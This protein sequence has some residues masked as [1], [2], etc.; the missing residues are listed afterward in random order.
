MPPKIWP[1]RYAYTRFSLSG[2][3]KI[4]KPGELLF[5]VGEQ[6]NGMYVLRKGQVLVYLDKGGT[7]IPLTTVGAGGMLGEMSLFDKKPRS[8]SAR[9]IDDVE[10]TQISNEDFTK[11]LQQIPKWF[12]TLMAT[13]S[14]RLRDTNERLQNLEGKYKGNFN[15]MEELTKILH[16]LH[17]LWYKSG[18]KELKNWILEREAAEN[19]VAAVLNMERTKV[20]SVVEACIMG[21]LIQAGKNSYKK[22]I[23]TILNRGD[24]ERFI[25][26]VS[27]LR[28]RNDTIKFL[29]Q[30]FV[31][32]VETLAK[33]AK[34]TAYDTFAI[35]LKS[36]QE[37]A[38]MRGFRTE[39]WG[40]IAPMFLDVDD[41]VVLTKNAK[42]LNLKVVK[43]QIDTL[44]QHAKIL[45]V[46]TRNEEKKN[47][48]A[49]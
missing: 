20:T 46:I 41:S 21:G 10:L 32:I 31:D 13:L 11:I 43:K 33:A 35:E 40:E 34:A 7:E 44:V 12:V 38:K 39:N 24:L 30:E 29:P 2:K 37:E 18:V 49:A 36:L 27:R 45:R 28:K 6:S 1:E 22:D 8:A 17:L 3:N 23:L 15:P 26:F 48:K 14:A 9:A 25:M 47:S 16:I 5:R 19:E 4:L 42:D